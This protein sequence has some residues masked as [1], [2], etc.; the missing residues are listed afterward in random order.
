[1]PLL[2]IFIVIPMVELALI[3]KVGAW[4]G[5]FWTICIIILTAVIGVR[6][7]KLQGINTLMKAGQRMQSGQLPAVELAEGFLL[8][9]AGALLLTPGFV[10]DGIG[11]SL[12]IP[13]VRQRLVHRVLAFIKPRMMAKTGFQSGF[14]SSFKPG[15][16][17]R[18]D[19]AEPHHSQAGEKQ[20]IEGEFSRDDDGGNKK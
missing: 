13:L 19:A 20:T 14:H 18:P 11:F 5:A 17:A 2:L 6:L 1:M 16:G 12:L 8:A 10:T 7:L 4:L 3:I 15:F 9:L